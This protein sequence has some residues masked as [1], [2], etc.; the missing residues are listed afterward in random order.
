LALA[1]AR[2]LTLPG[3]LDASLRGDGTAITR[4]AERYGQASD[5]AALGDDEVVVAG[6]L[7]PKGR[8]APRHRARALPEG[9]IARSG[10]RRHGMVLTG[11]RSPVRAETFVAQPVT[12][13]FRPDG[14]VVGLGT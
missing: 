7:M 2:S 10:L 6:K 4:L 5:V 11:H 12:L 1:P 13:R 8:Q 14:A 9:R 3:R